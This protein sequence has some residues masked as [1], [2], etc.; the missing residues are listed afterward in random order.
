MI[1]AK[2]D[3]EVIF[4]PL[5]GCYKKYLNFIYNFIYNLFTIAF[6]VLF[7]KEFVNVIIF[8]N[9]RTPTFT[10]TY[11]LTLKRLAC[12]CL[13]ITVTLQDSYLFNIWQTIINYS[14]RYREVNKDKTK[15]SEYI[16]QLLGSLCFRVKCHCFPLLCEEED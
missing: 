8:N 5:T 12:F 11:R 9:S 6:K 4:L 14:H 3:K 10:T 16:T 2:F 7:R 1:I 13:S 15:F